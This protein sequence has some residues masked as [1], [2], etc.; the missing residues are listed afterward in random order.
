MTDHITEESM[1]NNQNSDLVE[2][3]RPTESPDISQ[4]SVLAEQVGSEVIPD[5]IT[6]TNYELILP[7]GT[8]AYIILFDLPSII[9]IGAA[10]K[11]VDGYEG[12][13]KTLPTQEK[14][15][16]LIH[17]YKIPLTGI[18][19]SLFFGGRGK[20][21]SGLGKTFKGKNYQAYNLPIARNY[22]SLVNMAY[23]L[24]SFSSDSISKTVEYTPD[25]LKIIAKVIESGKLVEY[26]T[27]ES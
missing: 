10:D 25:N 16:P 19:V 7:D 1:G 18:F 4:Q 11:F 22:V 26:I 5:N 6:I 17:I 27:G 24:F 20:T 2:L 13:I 14:K 3:V 23:K 12:F 9:N 21:L 15:T 8:H